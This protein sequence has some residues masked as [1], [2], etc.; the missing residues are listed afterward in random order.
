MINW[1]I[2]VFQVILAV[3]LTH[4]IIKKKLLHF[5]SL[6]I[7][8]GPQK[9]H[10]Q[11]ISRLGGLVIFL[12]SSLGLLILETEIHDQFK[13]LLICAIP[14]TMVGFIDDI[15][16]NISAEL[17]LIIS[18][19]TG[20]LFSLISGDLINS[21]GISYF[22]KLLSNTI[23]QI[24]IT[25]L[26]ISLLIQ[27]FNVIDGLNGLTIGNFLIS[28]FSV[29]YITVDLNIDNFQNLILPVLLPTLIIFIYN[30]PSGKIFLGDGGAYFLGAFLGFILI[31]FSQSNDS[32]S[33]FVVLL[34]I[35]H[36]IYEILRTFLRR[37]FVNNVSAF[38][39]DSHHLHTLIFKFEHKKNARSLNVT[40]SIA[41]IKL[42]TLNLTFCIWTCYNFR[43]ESIILLGLFIFIVLYEYLYFYYKIKL[44]KLS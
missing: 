12:T 10:D 16:G 43:N 4:F 36:P 6:N 8:N 27:A 42:L 35:I 24:L 38:L 5:N 13:I 18:I 40:N 2:S 9:I 30:F 39:A 32:I 41:S 31:K 22:D 33:P 11:Q 23:F 44:E 15:Y 3:V 7:H 17:K 20:L 26:S 34:I 25:S 21:V 29:I 28:S 14:I 37:L 1:I 19:L